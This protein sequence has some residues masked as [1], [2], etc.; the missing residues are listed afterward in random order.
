MVGGYILILMMMMITCNQVITFDMSKNRTVLSFSAVL[1]K[2]A[3][4][5]YLN[6]EMACIIHSYLS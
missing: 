2:V 3:P 6:L 5:L 1:N 4:L